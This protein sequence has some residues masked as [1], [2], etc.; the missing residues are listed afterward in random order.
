MK[1]WQ[2]LNIDSNASEAEIKKAYK[3]LACKWHPDKNPTNRYLSEIK[4][5]EISNAY[6]EMM[7]RREMIKK[8]C[9]DSRIHPFMVNPSAFRQNVFHVMTDIFDEQ[10]VK[11]M[12][13]FT[14]KLFFKM[15]KKLQNV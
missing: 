14:E 11:P 8:S 9:N 2:V 10:N 4:F 5:K 12:F 3:T 15:G 7:S 6:N 1:P 13:S